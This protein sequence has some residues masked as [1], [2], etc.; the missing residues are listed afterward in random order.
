M[1]EAQIAE[2]YAKS[3]L[4]LAVEKNVLE[5]VLDDMRLIA[6][7]C[8]GSRELVLMLKSPIIKFDKKLAILN[9]IFKSRV[10]PITASFFE[11]LTKRQREEL[12]YPIVLEFINEYN[13]LKGIVKAQVYT[14]VQ[15]DDVLRTQFNKI[16]EE[17]TGKKV[18]LEEFVKADLVGGYILRIGDM[19]IDNSVKTKLN[20]IKRSF[21]E[22]HYIPKL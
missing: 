21:S 11:L 3:L 17:K 1:S 8:K 9:A 19:Q 10:H 7:S 4:E 16:V 22:N 15:I 5:P 12:L 2:R 13:V 20:N 6:A 14:P 18:E